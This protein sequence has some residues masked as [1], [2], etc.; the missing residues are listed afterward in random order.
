MRKISIVEQLLSGVARK[1]PDACWLWTRRKNPSG[2]GAF[3][4]SGVSWLAHRAAWTVS[5]GPIPSGMHVCHKCDTRPCCN[6]S[7]LFLGT[8]ADNVADKIAKG[9]GARNTRSFCSRGHRLTESNSVWRASSRHI[10]G[11]GRRCKTCC[12]EY[13]RKYRKD[14]ATKIAEQRRTYCQAYYLKNRDRLISKARGY[15]LVK[16]NKSK[17]AA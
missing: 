11:R 6:P 4:A 15:Y 17:N 1:N 13:M 16:Q 12:E 5:K 7:H 9:R 14:N 3:E 10:G 2:Y 8:N